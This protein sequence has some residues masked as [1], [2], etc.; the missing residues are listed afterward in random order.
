MWIKSAALLEKTSQPDNGVVLTIGALTSYHQKMLHDKFLREIQDAS[1][2][3]LQ[4]QVSIKFT[5]YQ[6]QKRS[7]D[8]SKKQEAPLFQSSEH[9]I[10]GGQQ[11]L[12]WRAQQTTQT[13]QVPQNQQSQ[14]P[15]EAPIHSGYN[16]SSGAGPS[17]PF[18][19]GSGINR[20]GLGS[21]STHHS[22]AAT[23]ASRAKLRDDYTFETLAVSSSNEMAHAAAMAVSQNP[24]RAYNPLFLY[25]G[26]GVG[27]THLMQAIGHNVLSKDPNTLLLYITGEQFT[28]EIVNAI[29]QKK[30]IPLKNRLRGYKVLLLDDVQFLAGRNAVQEEFF[31]TFNEIVT[32]GGQ[33][34]LTSDRPPH[35]ISLL[36]DRLRSRFEAGLIVDIQQPTFELRT[37]ILRIKAEKIGLD[38]PM[39]VAQKIAAAVESTR[40]LEGVLMGL[41]SAHSLFH[42]PITL[43]LAK[44]ILDDVEPAPF[45]PTL[46]K[47][48]E[49]VKAIAAQYKI[50][51]AAIKGP[52][53]SK[54]LVAARHLAMHILHRDLGVTLEEIGRMFGG[55]DHSSVLHAVEKIDGLL[56][57]NEGIKNSAEAIKTSLSFPQYR[58]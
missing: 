43:E 21:S 16:S 29:Q 12:G 40:R 7:S 1:I 22:M 13:Q 2:A 44:E 30:M 55:R 37:A 50:P 32:S 8:Q 9:P 14:S 23:M 18:G 26:V 34:V 20:S 52:S 4:T 39:E 47:P 11:D 54:H 10:G 46:V 33:V 56:L 15:Q 19:S 5:T 48:Q 49:V 58:G 45:V 53:R 35:E 42:K 27:K 28:N 3:V 57:T 25:G 36:E 31:H 51:A 38:L 24:G 41:H 17:S 6:P